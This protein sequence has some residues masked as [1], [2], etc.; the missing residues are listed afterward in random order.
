VIG[1]TATSD[2]LADLGRVGIVAVV[3]TPTAEEAV[4]LARAVV[5][6]GIRAVEIALTRRAPIEL[7][8][9]RWNSFALRMSTRAERACE[10]VAATVPSLTAQ[11]SAQASV[12]ASVQAQRHPLE[13]A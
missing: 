1:A 9:H 7:A 10:S 12:Q 3:R 6:G 4:D 13:P 2:V 5:A 11:A 8:R